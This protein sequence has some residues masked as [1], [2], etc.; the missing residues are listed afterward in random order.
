MDSTEALSRALVMHNNFGKCL[1][2]EGLSLVARDGIEPPTPAFSGLDS[3]RRICMIR[4]GFLSVLVTNGSLFWNGF[5]MRIG[6]SYCTNPSTTLR[7]DSG[8]CC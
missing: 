3:L 2:Q 4:Q 7:C 6:M 8:M 5:G 1:K